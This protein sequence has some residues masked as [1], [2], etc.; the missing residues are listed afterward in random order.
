VRGLHLWVENL[1]L[2]RLPG[3]IDRDRKD[4]LDQRGALRHSPAMRWLFLINILAV[5]LL[6][7]AVAIVLEGTPLRSSGPALPHA[8]QD[9]DVQP[10]AGGQEVSGLAEGLK[11]VD[12]VPNN[13]AA[14]PV[15]LQAPRPTKGEDQPEAEIPAA[16]HHLRIATEGDFAPFNFLDENGQPAGFD[17]DIASEL[18]ARLGR[19]CI[20]EIRAWNDLRPALINREVDVLVSSI[21]IPNETPGGI[22]FSDPYYGSR[23]RFVGPLDTASTSGEAFPYSGTQIAVQRDTVHAAYLEY[24][25]PMIERVSAETFDEAL[26]MVEAGR[27]E[28]AFGDNARAL[29]WLMAKVCCRVLGEPVSDP[30][31]FGRGMGIAVREDKGELLTTINNALEQM[32]ADG[33]H[34]RLSQNYF[35][36][37]IY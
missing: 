17:I 6:S 3:G 21:Q 32:V 13:G 24:A 10:D 2:L 25:Y 33:T 5:V 18:C 7:G 29:R 30:G 4:G 15:P 36:G 14:T 1:S 37:S 19:Q 27:V 20:F 28:G 31:F 16:P 35:S 11:E 26:A 9:A 23:G 34:A 12:A 22:V 8:G